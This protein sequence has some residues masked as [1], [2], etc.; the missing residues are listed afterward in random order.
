MKTFLIAAL[1]FPGTIYALGYEEFQLSGVD[2]SGSEVEFIMQGEDKDSPIRDKNAIVGVSAQ[3][4]GQRFDAGKTSGER[5]RAG[6]CKL[7]FDGSIFEC[8]SG[9][10]LLARAAYKGHKLDNE[11]VR[12]LPRV[13]RIFERYLKRHGYG[14]AGS[15]FECVRNCGANA[16]AILVLVWRGD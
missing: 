14:G 15:Y 8:N 6:H 3:F 9:P 11:S 7:M 13:N 4:S 10:G 16:P 5:F 12:K 1:L 2:G